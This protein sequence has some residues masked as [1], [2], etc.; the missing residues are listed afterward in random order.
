MASIDV[1]DLRSLADRARSGGPFR[2]AA[3]AAQAVVDAAF[4][5]VADTLALLR[6]FTT[7]PYAGLPAEDRELVRRKC[8]EKGVL[9]ALREATPVLTLLGTR[10]RRPGWSDRARSE[11]FRCIPL[12]T[13]AYV[14]AHSMLELQLRAMGFDPGLVDR[15]E[16]E[17]VAR[18]RA[19]GWS[20]TLYVADAAR[21]RD[22]QGRPAVPVQPFVA[23]NGIR[24]VVGCGAGY[25][26][27]PTLATLFAFT[28]ADLPRPAVEPFSLLLDAFLDLSAPLVADGRIFPADPPRG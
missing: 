2:C 9:P 6:I 12:V 4:P 15:W 21:D 27:H 20:G 8:E 1:A 24:T 18:G 10:G 22:P 13:G 26:R 14:A 5:P 28:T 17:V 25:R 7:V 3:D 16:E 23:E 19:D 11:R